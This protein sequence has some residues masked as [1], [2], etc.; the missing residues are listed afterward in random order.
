MDSIQKRRLAILCVIL[1]LWAVAFFVDFRRCTTLNQPI[2]AIPIGVS[3]DDGG[4]RTHLG[5]GYT[6]KVTKYIDPE[7]GLCICGTEMRLLGLIPIVI[8]V[9]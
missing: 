4:S 6:V 5:L 1:V 3:A 8:C 9:S 7:H 2:F